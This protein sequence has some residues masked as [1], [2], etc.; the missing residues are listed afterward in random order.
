[1]LM[2]PRLGG[3]GG[4]GRPGPTRRFPGKG[5]SSDPPSRPIPLPA[6]IPGLH[7][8]AEGPRPFVLSP[9]PSPEG[10]PEVQGGCP[11]VRGL[12]GAAGQEQAWIPDSGM[13]SGAWPGQQVR[14]S[15]HSSRFTHTHTHTHTRTRTRTRTKTAE[16]PSCPACGRDELPQ[17]HGPAQAFGAAVRLQLGTLRG[18]WCGGKECRSRWSPYH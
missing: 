4:T 6:T 14:I 10:L 3:T 11:Q 2:V 12:R 17:T 1:M 18:T 16:T 5:S 7:G 13:A 8:P 15:Q 9:L